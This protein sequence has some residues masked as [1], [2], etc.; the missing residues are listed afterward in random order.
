M[1]VVANLVVR[2]TAAT[3]DFDKQIAA[4]ERSFD[5][6]GA[7]LQSVGSK[8]TTG[9]TLPIVAIGGAAVKAAIDFESSFAGVRKTVDATDAEFKRLAQGIRD[10]AKVMPVSANELNR[11]AEAAGQLGVPKDNILDFTKTMAMLGETTNVTADQAAT[12]IAQIQNIFNAAGQNT[13]NFGAALVALGN[14]GASTE[15]EILELT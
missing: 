14:A 1:G 11:I 13:A 2:V 3:G 8:L 12:G 9:L 6:T 10:M 4:L 7:K 15:A 5:R